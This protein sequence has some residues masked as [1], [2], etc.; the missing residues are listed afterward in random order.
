MLAARGAAA[1]PHFRVRRAQ[2]GRELNDGKGPTEWNQ[3][4]DFTDGFIRLTE[5]SALLH[6]VESLTR[7]V[8]Q[9]HS[10]NTGMSLTNVVF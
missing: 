8:N 6:L 10:K 1:S 9:E 3:R 5:G 2:S 4:K 7:G